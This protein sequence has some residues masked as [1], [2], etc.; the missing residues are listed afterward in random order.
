[1]SNR[2]AKRAEKVVTKKMGDPPNVSGTKERC[3]N[4]ANTMDHKLHLKII[5]HLAATE[6][7][8]GRPAPQAVGPGIVICVENPSTTTKEGW[9]WCTR[10]ASGPGAR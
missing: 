2:H 8:L 4:C 10:W 3:S 6:L 9:G 7:A 1:M 5:A